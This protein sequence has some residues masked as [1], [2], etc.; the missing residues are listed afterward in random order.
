VARHV[1]ADRLR[2]VRVPARC[3]NPRRRQHLRLVGTV[4]TSQGSGPFAD[5]VTANDD[6]TDVKISVAAIV[7][8]RRLPLGTR[9]ND[10]RGENR[11]TVRALALDT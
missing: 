6:S 4:P 3:S 2:A 8:R 1:P 10:I 9:P 7:G 5:R 11:T